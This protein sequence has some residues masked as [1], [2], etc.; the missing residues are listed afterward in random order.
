MVADPGGADALWLT[1]QTGNAIYRVALQPPA[2]NTPPHDDHDDDDIHDGGDDEPR[3]RR[4]SRHA[5]AGLGRHEVRRDAVRHDLALPGPQTPVTYE[6][7]YGT[8]PPTAPQTAPATATATP[9]GASVSATL[10]G[11]TPYTTYHY[12]LV[13][14]D[15]SAASCQAASRDQTFTTGSTL[16]P[17]LNATVGATA[18]EGRC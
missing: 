2:T 16:Q 8:A 12:R 1:D 5:R 15:C 13:A 9:A 18:T 14:S 17:Q 4:F 6:F 11:L 10:S 7:Q 3:R